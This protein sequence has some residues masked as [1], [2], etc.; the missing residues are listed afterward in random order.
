MMSEDNVKNSA[1]FRWWDRKM[2]MQH[3]RLSPVSF[4]CVFV[5]YYADLSIYPYIS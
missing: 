1:Y 3:T 5:N 4:S 2:S